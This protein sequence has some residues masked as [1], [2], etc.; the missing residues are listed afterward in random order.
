MR[1]GFIVLLFALVALV[2][3]DE[4][5]KTTISVAD[6]FSAAGSGTMVANVENEGDPIRLKGKLSMEEGKFTIY[7]ADPNK[8]TIF[9]KSYKGYGEFDEDRSFD[10]IVGQWTFSYKIEALDKKTP[11]G[12]FDFDLIFKD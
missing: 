2:S 4:S 6:D 5:S 11:S 1:I 8:D 10:R 3:C 9:I 7:L 12:S